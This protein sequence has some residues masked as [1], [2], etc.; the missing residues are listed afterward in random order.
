MKLYRAMLAFSPD[1]TPQLFGTGLATDYAEHLL[2][3]LGASVQLNP[4]LE[5]PHPAKRWAQSGLMALTGNPQE[6]PLMC[7]V[8]LA[9]Q[10]DGALNAFRAITGKK[11]PESTGGGA[12]LMAER[13]WI[14]G[15]SRQGAISPGGSC[16]L[17]PSLDG[18]IGVNLARQSDWELL[19]AWLQTD[20]QADWNS[21]AHEVTRN[22]TSQ[23]LEQGQ[24]LGLAVADATSR[25]AA[26]V[27]WYTSTR[28]GQPLSRSSKL[29]RVLDL[30]SLWAGPLCSH[31]FQRAGATVIKVEGTQRPD[32]ARG[33]PSLF[34][35]LLNQGKQSVALD[36]HT[37]QGQ[38]QLRE[39]IKQ[40]DIVIEGS[41][42][43][44]LRQMGIIAEDVIDDNPGLTWLSISGY[45]RDE[46]Q[47]NQL[48][49]GDDAGVA[50][51][52][53]KIM[54]DV[55]G[56]WV[57]CGDAIAD[58]L[59]GLHCAL[60][61]WASWLAGGGELLDLSLH[62]TVAHCIDWADSNLAGVHERQKSWLQCLGDTPISTGAASHRPVLV[63]TATPDEHNHQSKGT[64]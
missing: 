52:L 8:P 10:A 59:T 18:Q 49:Y 26:N 14:A 7:P 12:E 53:S 27:N 16:H 43:R 37:V 61:G 51:G 32:G 62:Q 44:A 29:P 63:S 41:R 19:P 3:S 6:A 60:V 54:H 21:V 56:Q 36:L 4:G 34:F 30:S 2:T 45:G 13:A 20:V 39:L 64:H 46:P 28:C 25:T 48:A 23:L 5:D 38:R 35:E 17:L 9:S 24:L 47:A 11:V 1:V 31:L 40:V 42:P 58:P 22:T 55:T 57:I 50:A 33:G 15:H